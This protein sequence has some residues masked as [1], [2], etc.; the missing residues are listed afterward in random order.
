MPV[1]NRTLILDGAMG[2]QLMERGLELP[3]P[4]WSAETNITNP[5]D[6]LSVHCDYIK[7]GADIITTNTFRSTSWSYRKID[8]SPKRASERAKLSLMKAV[9]SA[10]NSKASFIAGSITSLEDCY[11]PDLFPGQSAAEDSYGETLMWFKEA[12]IEIILFETMGHLE[13]IEIALKAAS[14]FSKIWLSLII[15]D[16]SHL[17]S[18]HSLED[19]YVLSADRV[20]CMLLNC[21]TFDKSNDALV[22]F[23]EEWNGNWGIYPNLGE[24]EPEPDGAM[25]QKIDDGSFE[26]MIANYMAESP[27]I[28]GSCCGSSP[29]HT[30]MIRK[31]LDKKLL[32]R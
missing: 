4:L 28:I 21:N 19:V 8:L 10:Y 32:T 14:D 27:A 1:S 5:K 30:V 18:G 17:L 31:I 6:V 11:R 23:K 13:E 3:L 26:S 20:C 2:T 15:K 29:K 12:G 9:E 22:K 24:S 16:S 7:A 25:D